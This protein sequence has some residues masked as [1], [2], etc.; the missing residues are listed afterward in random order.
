[1][2]QVKNTQKKKSKTDRYNEP[3][4]YVFNRR[5]SISIL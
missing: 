5:E 4:K 3:I 2:S 1:M